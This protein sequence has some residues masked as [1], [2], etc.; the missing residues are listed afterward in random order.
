MKKAVFF[1]IDGT[2]LNTSKGVNKIT[3]PVKDSIKEL[4]KNDTLIFISSGRPYAFLNEDILDFGFD[5]YILMNGSLILLNDKKTIDNNNSNSNYIKPFYKNTFEKKHLKTLISKFEEYNIQY[6]LED[7]KYS[8]LKSDFRCQKS[9]YE[10]IGIS[11]K[12]IK[13]EYDIENINVCKIEMHCPDKNA[14]NFCK[15]LEDDNFRYTYFDEF[16]LFEL[17][18]RKDT[19][20]SGILKI[21]DYFNI[22]VNNSFAFGDS[23]NDIEMLNTVGCGIAMGNASEEIKIHADKVTKSVSED[24]VAHGINN[25]ILNY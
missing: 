15:T 8:Y 2:L 9:F 22:D 20:A 5:G 25:Y 4:Q 12:Y 6:I 13:N 10:D 17:Y 1:D 16:K 18:S 23:H 24:G 3:S 14:S 11:M 21:L 7:E 19:K